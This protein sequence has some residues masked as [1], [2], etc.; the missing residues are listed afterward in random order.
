[1]E[2]L[3]GV[4]KVGRP[5]CRPYIGADDVDWLGLLAEAETMSGGAQVLIRLAFDLWQAEV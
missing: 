1:M 4:A 5:R 3:A 2:L